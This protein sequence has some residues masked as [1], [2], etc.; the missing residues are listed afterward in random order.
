MAPAAPS[1]VLFDLD[2]TLLDTAPGLA[3]ALN[4][5]RAANGL[6]ALAFDRIRP[7]VSHGS[8]ALTRIGCDAD[9][10]SEAFER[11]R[12]ALLRT[13]GDNVAHGTRP[14]EG[15]EALLH[16]LESRS[17][18]WGVVTNKP[19]WLTGPLL[20]ALGLA[21]RAAVVISG[22]TA[23]EQKPH[24]AP[25]LLA[26]ERTATP[27]RECVYVGDAQ[28]DITAG[29]AAGMYTLVALYGYIGADDSPSTWGADAM[30]RTPLEIGNWLT[31]F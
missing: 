5:V 16:T 10:G 19:A 28:R 23:S 30:V 14:F 8:V 20:Q 18:P 31:S 29:N 24:P 4:R 2:G 15:T 11:F 21:A 22:D 9:E 3:W 26:A 27:P 17:I 25:L 13:Y 6:P 7:H 12:R 1:T